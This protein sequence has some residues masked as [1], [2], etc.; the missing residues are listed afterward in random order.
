MK[1]INEIF[2]KYQDKIIKSISL[3][4]KTEFDLFYSS[5]YKYPLLTHEIITNNTGKTNNS[6]SKIDRA[7]IIDPYRTDEEIPSSNQISVDEYKT[8]MKY[9][10]SPGH[11][12]P[13]GWHKTNM[14]VWS[15]TFLHT[16]M[17]PQEMTFNSGIWVLIEAW[18]RNLGG[19]ANLYDIHCI[20]GV[21][22]DN[23]TIKTAENIEINIPKYW[24]KILTVRHKE[25]N[26][27]IFSIA[28]MLPNEKFFI[29]FSPT[30]K[31]DYFIIPINKLQEIAKINL[32]PLYNYYKITDNTSTKINFDNLRK[33]IKLEYSPNKIIQ[34]QMEKANW[35]GK[36]IYANSL[37]QLEEIWKNIQRK[38][39][40]FRDLQYHQEYYEKIKERL[41][42]EKK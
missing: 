37:N 22:P 32:T 39:E 24:Y 1:I 2:E 38:K 31:F 16:N 26:N 34:I 13:A 20:S 15:E 41:I 36:I 21:I 5:Y 17:A 30:Y 11:S 35:F 14:K 8:L 33:I 3:L 7:N 27:I 42:E 40:K 28:L 4:K 6:S 19:N 9:G 25:Y 10:L 12:T 18:I 23:E 29:K